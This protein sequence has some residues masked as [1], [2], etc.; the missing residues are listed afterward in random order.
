MNIEDLK[1]KAKEIR[2]DII[3]EVY[4]A[5]SGHPGGSLSIADI[6]VTKNLNFPH[7]Y[8]SSSISDGEGVSFFGCPD[9][10]TGALRNGR[11]LSGAVLES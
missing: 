3:E 7:Y 6:K 1:M 5:N 9:A 4:N 11:M 10:G 8:K 2:K